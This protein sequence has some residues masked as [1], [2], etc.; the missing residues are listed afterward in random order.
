MI[1]KKVNDTSTVKY[2]KY[3]KGC[4]MKLYINKLYSAQVLHLLYSCYQNI[5]QLQQYLSPPG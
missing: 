3:V 2:N 5:P 1:N 4:N